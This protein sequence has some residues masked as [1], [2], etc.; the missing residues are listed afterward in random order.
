MKR[1]F[2]I[3]VAILV[4]AFAFAQLKD[5]PTDHWAYESI[6]ALVNAGIVQGYPDG[7]FRG[8]TNVTRYEVA[9]LLSRLMNKIELELGEVIK[10]RY[11]NS[12][13]LI[14]ANKGQ[15]SSLYKVVKGNADMLDELAAKVGDIEKAL[16]I[17]ENLKVTLDIHEGDITALYDISGKLKKELGGL[18]VKIDKM[19]S[20]L[21]THE[22]DIMAI[23]EEL[24]T[25]ASKEDVDTIVNDALANVNGQIEFLYKKINL[26]E[27][28]V[29]AYA[30]EKVSEL[31]GKVLNIE[32]TVNDGLPVLRDLVYQNSTNIKNLEVKLM[33]Y[34]KVK[35]NSVNKN[36]NTV[37]EMATFNSDTLNGLAMKLGEV[38]YALRKKV[39]DV[40]KNVENINANLETKADKTTV[41]ELAGKV[42]TNNVLSIFALLLG[43]AGLGV[44]IYGIMNP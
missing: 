44:A 39:E 30:D 42:K 4:S 17:V 12:L 27:E 19:N 24:K 36:L 1:Y 22:K 37:K 29:K 10:N 11:L 32:S 16:A 7:T 15:I 14:N 20:L 9:V 5:V 33:K 35:I 21:E 31:A 23:Y 34:I 2:V 8:A 13:K 26:S 43:A 3:I 38:E 18:N 28:N 40:E 6:E 41:D 25:K